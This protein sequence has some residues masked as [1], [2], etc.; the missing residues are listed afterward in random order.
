MKVRITSSDKT[1]LRY[2]YRVAWNALKEKSVTVEIKK[3]KLH[4]VEVKMKYKIKKFTCGAQ[5]TMQANHKF[6]M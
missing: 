4:N 2:C 3:N 6:K 5:M 1:F